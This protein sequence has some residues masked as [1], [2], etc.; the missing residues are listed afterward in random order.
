MMDCGLEQRG[1]TKLK[2]IIVP[3]PALCRTVEPQYVIN[4]V[5][6]RDVGGIF[7]KWL[8]RMPFFPSFFF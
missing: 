3:F 8:R 1:W 4:R 6:Q 2:V 7:R 5:L